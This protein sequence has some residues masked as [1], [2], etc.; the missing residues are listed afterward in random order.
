MFISNCFFLR[1]EEEN[2]QRNPWK[3][4]EKKLIHD[5]MAHK[6]VNKIL[7][8]KEDILESLRRDT[9]IIETRTWRNIQNYFSNTYLKKKRYP[10]TNQYRN[11]NR[12]VRIS[13]NLV[14]V[15]VW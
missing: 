3:E 9:E 5:N 1:C 12:Y 2:V 10:D 14:L 7:P 13:P 8:S 6:V 11:R 4:A 15:R